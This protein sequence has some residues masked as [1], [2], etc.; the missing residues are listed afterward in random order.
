MAGKKKAETTKRVK[1]HVKKDDMVVILTGKDRG[2]QGKVL[3]TVP[4]KQVVYVEKLN[5]QKR[6]TKGDGETKMSGIVSKEGP[7]HVSNVRKVEEG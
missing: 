6:H 4:S 7:I 5:M 2:Q 3:R 1:L